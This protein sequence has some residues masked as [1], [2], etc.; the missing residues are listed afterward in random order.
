MNSSGQLTVLL[1]TNIEKGIDLSTKAAND[2]V[3]YLIQLGILKEITGYKRK[4]LF[5]FEQYLSILM[6]S[7]K[8]SDL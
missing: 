8:E 6:R 5:A 2:V 7:G 3:R 4:Q 1:F